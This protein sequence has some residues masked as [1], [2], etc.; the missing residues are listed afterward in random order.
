MILRSFAVRG[1]AGAMPREGNF[2][3]KVTEFLG[4]APRPDGFAICTLCDEEPRYGQGIL[5]PNGVIPPA[6]PGAQRWDFFVRTD[7]EPPPPG[8]QVRNRANGQT[9]V[10]QPKFLGGAAL[11]D[12]VAF[13]FV[14]PHEVP[15]GAE[16]LP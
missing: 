10:L 11:G 12:G 8:R 15:A 5:L 16:F 2:T 1:V 3:A 14:T 7:N 4:V 13:V 6:A 9:G